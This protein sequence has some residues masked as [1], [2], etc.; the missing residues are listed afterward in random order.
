MTSA[1]AQAGSRR[2]AARHWK[3]RVRRW[4][5]PFTPRQAAH[6]RRSRKPAWPRWLRAP[7]CSVNVRFCP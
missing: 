2:A 6:M 4:W 1:L 3:L 5:A 7:A